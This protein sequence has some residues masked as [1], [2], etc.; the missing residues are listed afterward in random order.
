MGFQ[1]LRCEAVFGVIDLWEGCPHCLA[2]GYPSSVTARY[3]RRPATLSNGA[4]GLFRFSDWLPYREFPSLGEGGTVLLPLD[5][6]APE[7]GKGRMFLKNEGSN[8]TGS[9]KDRMSCLAVARAAAVGAKSVIAASSGNAGVSLAAYAAAAGLPCEIVATADCNPAYRRAMQM[10]G[11]KV[12]ATHDSLERW[13]YMR[14][15]VFGDG[16]FPVTNYLLPPVGSNPFGVEGYKTIAFEIFEQ[17]GNVAPDSILAPTD[18]ADLAWGLYCG[19]RDLLAAGLT[20][21]L[22]RLFAVEPFPRISAVVEGADYRKEF[23][24]RTSMLSIAGTTVTFQGIE[25]IRRTNG[26][27]VVAR[28]EDVIRDQELMA[29]NG[30][31]LELSCACVLTGMR[32][33]RRSGRVA[34]DD[35]VV[36]IGT[37]SGFK[38]PTTNVADVAFVS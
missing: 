29:R 34:S 6:V 4:S 22:P 21:K 23:K 18:R 19:F 5:V 35:I 20:N 28:D 10:A 25:A 13:R 1:C 8:P 11:A 3:S 24:G 7:M 37:S 38:D 2:A 27:A 16:F 36:A 30:I 15:R 12:V 9:H 26:S 17:L 31:Y 14:E 33:L 32:Q